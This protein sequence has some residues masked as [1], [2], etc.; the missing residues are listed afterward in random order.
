MFLS[1]RTCL[2]LAMVFA[3]SLACVLPSIPASN[4]DSASTSAAQNGLEELPSATLEILPTR[5]F[6]PTVTSAPLNLSAITAPSLTFTPYSIFGASTPT[7]SVIP[8]LS[9]SAPTNCRNGPGKAYGVEGTLMKGEIVEVYARSP[10]NEYFYIR[11]PDP[12]VEFCWVWGEY[13]SASGSLL[14]LPVLLPPPTPSPTMTPTPIP[15]FDMEFIDSIKCGGWMMNI[16]VTNTSPQ[17]FKSMVIEV[18]DEVTEVELRA[19]SDE[20]TQRDGCLKTV[21]KDRIDPF[22]TFIIS[23]PPFEYNPKRHPF[24]AFI[25]LCTEKGQSAGCITRKLNFKP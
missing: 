7:S 23:S 14:V 12:G 9:V 13:A 11:N 25:T 6:T 21:T 22:E 8:L 24:R 2:T 4:T 19:S 3:V 17:P 10:T 20:F 1:R 18:K 16:Q 15:S 5:T